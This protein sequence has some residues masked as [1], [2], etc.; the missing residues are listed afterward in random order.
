MP[1]AAG[2]VRDNAN[3][4]ALAFD[5]GLGHIGCAIG[6][7]LGATARPLAFLKARDGQPDWDAVARLIAEWQPDTLLVG[8]PLNM[9]GS[10]SDFCLR[11]RKFARRLHGRF[12]LPVAMID[13]R[14][15]SREA[16]ARGGHRDSYRKNPVDDLAAQVIL[17]S[18]LTDPGQG[19]AP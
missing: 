13:E 2:D 11:A 6:Q 16:K 10:E 8:L 15:S 17:E 5:Y 18:W 12:G 3:V 1:E 4:T 7:T 19:L 14:L 9:D